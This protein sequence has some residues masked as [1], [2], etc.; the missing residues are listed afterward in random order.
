[1]ETDELTVSRQERRFSIGVLM[2]THWR[3][4]AGSGVKIQ[5]NGVLVNQFALVRNAIKIAISIYNC[6]CKIIDKKTITKGK[7]F[8]L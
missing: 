1:M 5:D 6:F 7:N 3:D 2:L 4:Q 8:F